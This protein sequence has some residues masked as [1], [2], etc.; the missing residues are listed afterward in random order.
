MFD[1]KGLQDILKDLEKGQR[2]I[3][4]CSRSR[5]FLSVLTA[6]GNTELEIYI[7]ND[8]TSSGAILLKSLSDA[9]QQHI[10]RTML[11]LKKELRLQFRGV[12]D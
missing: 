1:F 8:P 4:S 2:F 12:L 3:D 11:K 6:E 5:L 9:F 7:E 10:D